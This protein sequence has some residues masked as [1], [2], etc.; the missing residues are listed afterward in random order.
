[1]EAALNEIVVKSRNAAHNRHTRT[2]RK[3]GD[4]SAHQ[5]G[6]VLA[7]GLQREVA[8]ATYM[9]AVRCLAVDLVDACCDLGN[10]GNG[11]LNDERRSRCIDVTA[12]HL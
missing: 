10:D 2:N 12:R 11:R 7:G 8:A 3:R 6:A 5:A 4:W 1:M 9:S